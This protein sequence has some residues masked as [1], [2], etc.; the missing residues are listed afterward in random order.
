MTERAPGYT[1]AAA[2]EPEPHWVDC[3]VRVPDL[4]SDK[5]T[6]VQCR[7]KVRCNDVIDALDLDRWTAVA[8]QHLWRSSERARSQREKEAA[9]WYLK[10]ATAGHNAEATSFAKVLRKLITMADD[11]GKDLRT[12]LLSF[13]CDAE[14]A[15]FSAIELIH[16]AITKDP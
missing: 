6:E 11:Q 13:A 14:M 16:S 12:L 4:D 3:S 1:V 5:K 9:L 7:A 10:R 15:E 2:A 8:F